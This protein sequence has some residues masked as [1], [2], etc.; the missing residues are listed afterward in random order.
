MIVSFIRSS[1]FDRTPQ[2]GVHCLKGT[3]RRPHVG[4]A[5]RGCAQAGRLWIHRAE[6]VGA[7]CYRREPRDHPAARSR[8]PAMHQAADL[9]AR[10]LRRYMAGE[11]PTM[12]PK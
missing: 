2:L 7:S 12:R 8:R 11:T 4:R 5:E 10:K 9:R 6:D 3:A 1:L